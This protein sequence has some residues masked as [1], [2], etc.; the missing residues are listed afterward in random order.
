MRRLELSPDDIE[1]VHVVRDE[2]YVERLILDMKQNGWRG[3]SLLVEETVHPYLR[4]PFGSRS[5][6]PAYFA[7]TGSHRLVAA[8]SASLATVPCVTLTAEEAHEAFTRASYPVYWRLHACW[9]DAITAVE[10]PTDR[11][12]LRALKRAGLMEAAELLQL[13]IDALDGRGA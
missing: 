4:L 10:G 8:V 9:R 1:P 11:D 13:E 2:R 3:R 12:R 5:P 6:L 7:W